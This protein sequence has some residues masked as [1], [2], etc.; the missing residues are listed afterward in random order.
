VYPGQAA[1]ELPPIFLIPLYGYKP[2]G[3]SRPDRGLIPLLWAMFPSLVTKDQTLVIV[4]S[5]HTPS[6]WKAI[7]ESRDNEL[8]NSITEIAGALIVDKTGDG[9]I[10]QNSQATQ[11]RIDHYV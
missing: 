3:D 6:N 7:V 9:I 2:S 10:L 11:T 1:N 4:Y 8:W 5:K